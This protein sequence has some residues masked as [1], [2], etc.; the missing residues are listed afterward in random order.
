[1]RSAEEF[2]DKRRDLWNGDVPFIRTIQA[3]ALRHAARLCECFGRTEDLECAAMLKEQ[4]D[5]LEAK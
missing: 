3:D 5:M 2:A 4:A 1:M